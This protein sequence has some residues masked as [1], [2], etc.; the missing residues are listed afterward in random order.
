MGP[1][2]AAAASKVHDTTG[3]ART[4]L[5]RPVLW[6]CAPAFV[7][8]RLAPLACRRPRFFVPNGAQLA[9]GAIPA[10]RALA[11]A[12]RGAVGSAAAVASTLLLT[13][14]RNQHSSANNDLVIKA[15]TQGLSV[16]GCKRC[17][18][19]SGVLN[20]WTN[21]HAAA[22]LDDARCSNT[23]KTRSAS[24]NRAAC[25]CPT[26]IVANSALTIRRRTPAKCHDQPQHTP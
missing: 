9:L 21:F 17:A 22:R 23:H 6:A 2:C 26:C 24:C 12:T 3:A 8:H 18:N 14:P 25:S 20:M 4:H 13:P 1:S 7:Q 10:R 16:T 5:G 15:L 19:N 11:V